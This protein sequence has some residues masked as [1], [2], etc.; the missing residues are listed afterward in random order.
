[1]KR[2][3]LSPEARRE[4][5]LEVAKRSIIS[6][7]LQQ[8]SLKNLAV[9]AKISEPL[10]YHYFNSRTDL[11]QQVL[12][13][14]FNQV[15]ESLNIALEGADSLRDI[16]DIYIAR[17]YD[18]RDELSLIDILLT[19]RDVAVVIE[20]KMSKQT[21]TQ[22]KFL[23]D[24]IST[25]FGIT[26]KQASML[27]LMA[28]AASIAAAKYAFRSGIGRAEEIETATRFISAGFESQ[29]KK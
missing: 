27:A 20:E 22:E 24:T 28:S 14:D 29:Y 3:R 1:M 26:R 6:D 15:I 10:L 16:L 13:K 9:E 25:E 19:D 7:G 17:D 4:E 21:R 11:L 18:Q 8:F 5:L 23:V 2:T 12:E